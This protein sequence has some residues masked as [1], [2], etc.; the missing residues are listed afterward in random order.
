M[1]LKQRISDD[2]KVALKGGDRDKAGTLR[3]L[4]GAIQNVEIDKLK[5]E[6]GLND[7]EVI[8]VVSRSIKQRRDSIEQFEKGG[9]PELAAKEKA[10]IDILMAY[11]PAQLDEVAVRQIVSEVI[12]ESGAASVKDMGR[13]MGLVMGRVKGQADGTMIRQLVENE[14]QKLAG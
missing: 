3:L 13:V 14:L 9:R 11:M 12:K 7:E 5:R 8:E 4:V 6:E 2:L 10:E 1:S